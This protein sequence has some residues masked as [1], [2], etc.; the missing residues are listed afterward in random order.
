MTQSSELFLLFVALLFFCLAAAL[1]LYFGLRSVR[2]RVLDMERVRRRQYADLVDRIERSNEH[3]NHDLQMTHQLLELSTQA[4]EERIERLLNR[5]TLSLDQQQKQMTQLREQ[6]DTRLQST[7]ESRLGESFRQVN[8]QL[9]RVYKGL[10]EMQNLAGSV[11]DL[12]KM[13]TGVK[14]RGMWGEVRLGVLLEECLSPGQYLCD[15][16][17]EP[18]ASERVEFAVRLPGKGESAPVL[19]P[20]DAKFPLEDHQRLVDAAGSGDKVLVEKC[21]QAL[22]RSILAEAKRIASKYIRVPHTTDFAVM[23]LP[24]ESLYAE[25][26]QRP[27]AIQRIQHEL[28]VLVA[29]PSTLAALL[30][31]LQMGFRTLAVEQRSEEIWRL[32]GSVRSEFI[33]F[34]EILDRTRQHLAKAGADLDAAG[35]RSRQITRELGKVE[36]LSVPGSWKE[37]T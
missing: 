8:A 35:A 29:G 2:L 24:T 4:G 13:L 22:E 10:G 17:V 21:A 9:E 1:I 18:G 14:T 28:R 15:T 27:G 30:N 11:G 23:F 12:K 6:V 19:L 3:L 31:S 20:I 16:P 36:Q 33:R 32:L 25:V 37:E 7:L 26:L 5:V 34:G